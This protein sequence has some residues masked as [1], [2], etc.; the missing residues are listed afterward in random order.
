MKAPGFFRVLWAVRGLNHALRYAFGCFGVCGLGVFACGAGCAGTPT[1]AAP[2]R[3]ASAPVTQVWPA[4]SGRLRA[5]LPPLPLLGT[6]AQRYK[7]FI[8]EVAE[9]LQT[10]PP[11]SRAQ[12]RARDAAKVEASLAA[13]LRFEWAQRKQVRTLFA[14]LY[15]TAG[16]TSQDLLPWVLSGLVLEDQAGLSPPRPTPGA[17]PHWEEPEPLRNAV[18]AWADEPGSKVAPLS[19]ASSAFALCTKFATARALEGWVAFCAQAQRRTRLAAELLPSCTPAGLVA[20]PLAPSVAAPARQEPHRGVIVLE[21]AAGVPLLPG[22]LDRVLQKVQEVVAT[23][24][25]LPLARLRSGRV[26]ARC[27]ASKAQPWA[28]PRTG[29]SGDGVRW[30]GVLL[31]CQQATGPCLLSVCSD[32]PGGCYRAH[33]VQHPERVEEWIRA[34]HR[35]SKDPRVLVYGTESS[36]SLEQAWALEQV[37]WFGRWPQASK[38]FKPLATF[39]AAVIRCQGPARYRADWV[40]DID[41]RGRVRQWA[42]RRVWDEAGELEA[43]Q[44]AC[45]GAAV[46]RLRF[47]AQAT[48]RAGPRRVA[49]ALTIPARV[50]IDVPQVLRHGPGFS[51]L[52]PIRRLGRDGVAEGVARCVGPRERGVRTVGLCF[53]VDPQ[54]TVKDVH[55]DTNVARSGRVWGRLRQAGPSA[56]PAQASGGLASCLQKVLQTLPWGCSAK[57]KARHAAVTLTLPAALLSRFE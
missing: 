41:G 21:D 33:G 34:T 9:L 7:P 40:L 42:A 25:G 6:E 36:S 16:A 11:G 47:G 28:S 29:E 24:D 31:Q 2:V 8:D 10:A 57:A 48:G 4:A 39:S 38:A 1:V 37:G 15:A 56:R 19:L 45:L 5:W 46:G 17:P 3:S 20:G 30:Y 54:G 44:A 50:Q 49:F 13:Q 18:Q 26:A 32:G 27:R 52:G 14:R 12:R 51:P 53:E 35:L 55:V 43:K 23:G 22:E